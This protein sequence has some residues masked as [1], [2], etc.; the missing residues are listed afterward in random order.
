MENASNWLKE[1]IKDINIAC[2]LAGL[3]GE[4]E[5]VVNINPQLGR[6]FGDPYVLNS[7]EWSDEEGHE[8]VNAPYRDFLCELEDLLPLREHTNLGR[9]RITAKRIH[10]ASGGLVAY[11]MALVRHATCLALLEGRERLDDALLAEAFDQRL[12]GKRRGIANPFR[13][14]EW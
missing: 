6:L 8:D 10:Q 14:A 3:Q 1:F 2:V 7:F 13:D 11:T 9:S 4:A 12:A 5:H